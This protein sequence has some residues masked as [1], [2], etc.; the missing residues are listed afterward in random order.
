MPTLEATLEATLPAF[1]RPD[2]P[3]DPE[4]VPLQVFL[5]TLELAE[6]RQRLTTLARAFGS[7][8]TLLELPASE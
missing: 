2:Q 5:L 3:P 7:L 1:L 6:M 8:A 4:M